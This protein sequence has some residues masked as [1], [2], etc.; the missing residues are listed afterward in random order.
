MSLCNSLSI[1]EVVGILCAM[2]GKVFLIFLLSVAFFFSPA[3]IFRQ[4]PFQGVI[5]Y[6]HGMVFLGHDRFYRVG[7]LPA[8]WKRMSPRAR[9]VSFYNA[10]Y[11]GSISTDAFCGRSISDR[12]LGSLSGEI[13][14]AVE[15]RVVE[16]EENFELNG[17]GALRQRV[18]GSEDGV[19]VIVDVVVVRKDGCV[20][21]FYAV[22]PPNGN[23]KIKS[24][25]ETF[26][27]GFDY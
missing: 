5:G 14:S 24:D 11:R 9:T 7:E 16:A 26:F 27:W 15:G 3:C 6:R 20:F 2:R 17:R 1:V 13:I 23:V 18:R 8:G 4:S 19:P 22:M 10:E 21:D 25:F 12:K